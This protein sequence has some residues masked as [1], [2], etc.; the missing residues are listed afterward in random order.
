ML[1]VEILGTCVP[2]QIHT[3][4]A[5]VAALALATVALA[6]FTY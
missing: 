6:F 5:T 3:S 1:K 2:V 4:S